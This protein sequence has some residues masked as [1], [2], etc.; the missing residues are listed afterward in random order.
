MS[1]KGKNI[2]PFRIY[3]DDERSQSNLRIFDVLKRET[4]ISVGEISAK[5]NV[6]EEVVADYMNICVKNDLIK[7]SA[8]AKGELADLNNSFQKLLGIGFCGEEC[9]LTGVNLE[10]EVSWREYVNLNHILGENTR[11]KDI[12]QIKD[13]IE[14]SVKSKKDEYHFTGLAIPEQM[15][16]NVAK[17]LAKSI[18]EIFKGDILI[19][20]AATASGYAEKS[21]K[22]KAKNTLYMYRD[23][24]IGVV[25]KNETIYE[26][27]E[28]KLSSDRL[29]LRPWEQFDIIK[30]TKNLVNKGVGTDIVNMVGGDVNKITLEIVLSAAQKKDELAEDLIKRSGLALGVRVAYLVNIFSPDVVIIGGG[31]EQDKKDFIGFVEESA[32]K[33]LLKDKI[34]KLVI[35]PGELGREVSSIGAALLCRREMFMEV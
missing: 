8:A 5:A 15:N 17:T 14:K 4:A 7:I 1:I 3:P 12:S 31:I 24:G 34:D 21:H 32:K 27:G 9:I 2:R 20:K 18:K 16:E 30:T 35:I 29:Y 13:K 23:I 25:L 28:S 6:S 11:S 19:V 26:T 33:F 10:G 22:K